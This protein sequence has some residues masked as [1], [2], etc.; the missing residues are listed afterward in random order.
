[1]PSCP[2]QPRWS[3]VVRP[4]YPRRRECCPFPGLGFSRARLVRRSLRRHSTI[5]DLFFFQASSRPVPQPKSGCQ[6]ERVRPFGPVE[7]VSRL[8]R[9]PR[10][11]SP[12]FGSR[13]PATRTCDT[14]C[15]DDVSFSSLLMPSFSFPLRSAAL[16]PT[17]FFLWL[18]YF[19]TF[20]TP[21]VFSTPA[22]RG[23]SMSIAAFADLPLSLP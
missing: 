13:A 21:H 16:F 3:L 23:Q 22:A 9:L 19:L 14:S 4:Q 5:L 10:A 6:F 15:S 20:C 18:F 8:F 1:L 11:T 17:I 7:W 2:H 12:G